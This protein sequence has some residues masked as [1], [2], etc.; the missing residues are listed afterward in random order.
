V[1]VTDLILDDV[2]GIDVARDVRNRFARSAR[3]SVLVAWT[4]QVVD[5]L[6][7][8]MAELFD[9]CIPK[10]ILPLAFAGSVLAAY[11]RNESRCLP[12]C[13]STGVAGRRGLDASGVRT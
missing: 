9:A 6:D 10:P 4:A 8:E 2:S 7:G 3:P 5:S 11:V 12:P 1:I 13:C